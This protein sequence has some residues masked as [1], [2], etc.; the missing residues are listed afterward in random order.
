LPCASKRNLPTFA[1]LLVNETGKEALFQLNVNNRSPSSC[2]FSYFQIVSP[3]SPERWLRQ[4]SA[5]L[6]SATFDNS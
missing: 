5:T 1:T 2:R 3:R 4:I 6:E